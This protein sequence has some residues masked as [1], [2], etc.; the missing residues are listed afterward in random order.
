MSAVKRTQVLLSTFNGAK[1]LEPLLQSV[2]NQDYP[3]LEII[4]R[5]DGSTDGT[6]PL[7]EHYCKLY[8]NVKLL[9]GENI[10]PA[11]SFLELL[12]LADADY[13][14]FCDQDDVWEIDKLSRA[15]G[16][17]GAVA[18][19]IP[20][21]YCAR[22]RIVDENLR[23][24]G[25]SRMPHRGLSFENALV[26]NV[27]TGC[28]ILINAKARE[29]IN[30]HTPSF[31]LMHDWW[32]YLVVS[33]FGKVVY[34]PLPKVYYRQ[35][36]ANVIGVKTGSHFW[37]ARVERFL[38]EG[39]KRLVR[40]QAQEFA[41][42]YGARLPPDKGAIL[43]RFLEGRTTLYQKI[44]YA[45]SPDVYRQSSIDNLILRVLLLLDYV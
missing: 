1:Y 19:D 30:R 7:L 24:I 38:R 21:L 29:L 4:V 18:E 22:V 33:A 23:P 9:K 26:E 45:F 44:R 14:A 35:H 11:Q 16:F 12:R 13:V 32:A 15:E 37:L 2:L 5:D 41:T 43:A 28:T 10:G 3:K 27:A 8:S 20:A 34:D 17:L 36:S 6:V 25:L 40:R 31:M 42:V 39:S